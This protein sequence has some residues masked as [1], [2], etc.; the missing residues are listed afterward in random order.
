MCQQ[1]IWELQLG[2]HGHSRPARWARPSCRNG[3]CLQALKIVDSPPDVIVIRTGQ[4]HL[5]LGLPP[6]WRSLVV[7][8]SPNGRRFFL[9]LM[10]SDVLAVPGIDKEKQNGTPRIGLSANSYGVKE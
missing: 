8:A 2:L 4:E 1:P 6:G 5:P 10:E 3:S 9:F 7:A